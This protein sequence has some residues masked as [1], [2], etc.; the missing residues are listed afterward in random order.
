MMT[1]RLEGDPDRCHGERWTERREALVSRH[2][3]LA[4][5]AGG[6]RRGDALAEGEVRTETRTSGQSV[7]AITDCFANYPRSFP[8]KRGCS[9]QGQLSRRAVPEFPRPQ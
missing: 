3:R 2:V 7:V 4:A 6:W 5:S 1:R 8:D 9:S